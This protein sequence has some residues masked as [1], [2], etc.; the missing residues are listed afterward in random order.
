MISYSYEPF[1]VKNYKSN[2]FNILR[3]GGIIFL[4]GFA[5]CDVSR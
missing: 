5:S 3:S 4:L 2:L 1:L